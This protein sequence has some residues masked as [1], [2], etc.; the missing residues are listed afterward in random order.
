[1]ARLIQLQHPTNGRYVALAD[2]DSLFL[3]QGFESVYDLALRALETQTPLS[4]LAASSVTQRPI[5]YN[6]IYAGQSEWKILPPLDHPKDPARCLVSGTGLTHKK[7][8]ANRDA[9]HNTGTITD[10]M[11]VY[12]WGEEGGTPL[13]G[14]IG[15][16]PEWFYKG[17]GTILRAHGEPL[18]IPEFADDGGEEPEIAGLYII[19]SAGTP[20]RV[21]YAIGNEFSDHA[22]EK[23]NYLYLAPSKLRTCSIGP[24]LHTG[25]T[26]DEVSG[27]VRV[28]RAGATLW[29]AALRSGEGH[30]VHSLANLE[31]HHFKYPQHC[32]PG[33][34]HVH[35]FGT[36]AFSFGAG[37]TLQDGD[38]MIVEFQ[39]FG[40]AL[41][42][43]LRTV[44]T[45]LRLTAVKAL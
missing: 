9:M 32:R 29:S 43:P 8:A 10:S 11:K 30:M 3:L 5:D 36:S 31:H 25:V 7:S 18:D 6:P 26:F 35:Y 33:D 1:M 4:H 12:Q 2:G 27:T 41:R 42:N 23:K 15:A 39:N 38:E 16:Q 20:R 14:Q 17:P 37:V 40:R 44:K 22:M 45:P 28:E 13:P 21:G 24:E 19:D 34:V